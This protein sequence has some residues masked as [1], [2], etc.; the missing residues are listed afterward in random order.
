MTFEEYLAIDAWNFST[1]KLMRKSPK[2]AAYARKV[3][4]EERPCMLIGSAGHCAVLEPER[5]ATDWVV[6]RETPRRQ[7]KVYDAFVA[8]NAGKFIL[9]P[10]EYDIVCGARDALLE[11]RVAS[12]YLTGGEAE[13]VLQWTD[14]KTEIPLKGRLDY[15]N[16]HGITDLKFTNTIDER[17]IGATA[18]RM[19]YDLQLALYREGARRNGRNVPAARIVA[20]EPEPPFA[21]G[22]FR[23][24]DDMLDYAFEE[25]RKLLQAVQDCTVLDRWPGPYE[26]EQILV[27]PDWRFGDDEGFEVVQEAG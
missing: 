27:M 12:R 16:A 13:F 3:P 7:G 15:V 24:P 11:D 14:P 8:A 10:D 19:G 26:D 6:Y 20:V 2:H 23:I 5:F 4:K 25:C 17:M 9:K 18:A 1:L 21:V 22:V